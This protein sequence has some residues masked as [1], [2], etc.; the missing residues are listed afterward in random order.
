MNNMPDPV[1][2][3]VRMLV[4]AANAAPQDGTTAARS[5]V[6]SLDFPL[7][8]MVPC[9]TVLSHSDIQDET[10]FD[11]MDLNRMALKWVWVG[12]KHRSDLG[13]YEEGSPDFLSEISPGLHEAN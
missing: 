13:A 11:E 2:T 8:A 12:L 7:P 3:D 6:A 4:A 9:M 1:P 5:F 10:L